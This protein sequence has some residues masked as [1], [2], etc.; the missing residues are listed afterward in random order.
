MRKPTKILVVDVEATCWNTSVPSHFRNEIIEIGVTEVDIET[1]NIER[2]KSIIVY[3]QTMKIS[4]FCTKLT[5]LTPEF[6]D[7]YGITFFNAMKILREDFDSKNQI[8]AS[9]GDYDRKTFESNC[10]WNGE[11]YPFGNMHLNVKALFAAQNGWTGGQE[12]CGKTLGIEMVGTPHRGG[13]DALNIAKILV[14][15][16]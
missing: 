8:F 15:L 4:E 2:T 10:K 5:T 9:W 3:P 7:D 14:E 11:T 1:K 12:S 16:L 6:V 13:D